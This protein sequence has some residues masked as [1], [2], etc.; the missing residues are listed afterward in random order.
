M[1]L[2][3]E[4]FAD[5]ETPR[6]TAGHWPKSPLCS[7]SA[8]DCKICWTTFS[9]TPSCATLRLEPSDL[10]Q[11]IE[12]V[13]DLFAPQAKESQIELI[14]YLDR[15]L[16]SVVLDRESF[17]GALINLVVNALQAMPG[18]GQLVVRTTSTA[19]GV[20]LHLI[21]TGEGMDEKTRSQIFETFLFDQA[22]RIRLG[23]AH[24]TQN[25]R[26]SRRPDRGAKRSRPGHAVHDRIAGPGPADGRQGLSS[27]S[28][29]L[30]S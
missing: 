30:K 8:C 7:V 9:I 24:H 19:G 11:Q 2:L 16:P 3:A 29:S 17:H 15:Q 27:A 23:T 5:A 12:R 1:E 6:Q 13:L 26:S 10:N 21:D 4:D 18:G 28:R 25:H 14:C 20:A 22:G